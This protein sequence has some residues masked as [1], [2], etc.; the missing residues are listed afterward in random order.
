MD[1]ESS[2]NLEKAEEKEEQEVIPAPVE[3]ENQEEI[4]E[5]PVSEEQAQ[6]QI[7]VEEIVEPATQPVEIVQEVTPEAAPEVVQE[8]TEEKIDIQ[9]KKIL[10]EQFV[11][12]PSLNDRLAATAHHESKI[13]GKPVT[14]I[15]SAIGLNDR[16][17]YTRELF[18]NES[19]K[20]E[21]TVDHLDQLNNLHEAVDYL[22]KNFQWTK[23]EAS[24]KFM[25]LVKRRFEN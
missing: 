23:N 24:L 6:E 10:G 5:E 12:E 11:K 19:S 16:F 22:S 14:K 21:T 18:G 17:L 3:I 9:E 7:P 4:R 8:K 1:E 13:K 15:K 20:F 2:L 25:E